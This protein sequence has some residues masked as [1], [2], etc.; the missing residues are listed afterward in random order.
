MPS[1]LVHAELLQPNNPPLGEKYTLEGVTTRFVQNRTLGRIK[2]IERPSANE[3]L[4]NAT[5]S[6]T[7]PQIVSFKTLF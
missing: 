6:T 7:N 1:G 4:R 2:A 5:S 3:R